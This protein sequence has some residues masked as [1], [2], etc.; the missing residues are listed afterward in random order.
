[1]EFAISIAAGD[2]IGV[3]IPEVVAI[4]SGHEDAADNDTAVVGD[5]AAE[6][7]DNVVLVLMK[8]GDAKP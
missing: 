1:M 5:S 7:D 8:D 2:A 3:A 6:V 4:E